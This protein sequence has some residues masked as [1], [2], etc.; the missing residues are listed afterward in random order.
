[1]VDFPLL[2]KLV[3][4]GAHFFGLAD[5]ANLSERNLPEWL[6]RFDF[7]GFFHFLPVC[8]G[9]LVSGRLEFLFIKVLSDPSS[10]VSDAVPTP[11]AC[12]PG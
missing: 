7:A 12:H 1:M 10:L 9:R 5:S 11:L 8:F 4:T 2:L 6:R 3:G